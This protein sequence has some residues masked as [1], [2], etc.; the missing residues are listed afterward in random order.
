MNNKNDNRI[1]NIDSI[2]EIEIIKE[3]LPT[4]EVP[5]PFSRDIFLFDTYIA[6]TSYIED[7]EE[8]FDS[9][10]I[11]TELYFYREPQNI[12]DKYAIVIRTNTGKKIGF[13]PATDNIVFA[14]LMD[15]GKLLIAKI[16]NLN[17]IENWK[18]IGIKIYL[19]D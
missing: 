9:I 17:E 15:A 5:K 19:R 10:N 2:G 8:I 7:I 4:K 3:L 16:S 11:D 6:G 12:Y 13:V 1:A 14:R 18:R